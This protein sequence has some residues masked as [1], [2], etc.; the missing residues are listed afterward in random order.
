MYDEPNS[1]L[2]AHSGWRAGV[3]DGC[4]CVRGALL[5]V[6]LLAAGGCGRGRIDAMVKRLF[7]PRLTP[8]QY[9]LIAVSDE[10]PDARR[11]AV[12]RVA[13]S[14]QVG[15]EWALKGLATVAL[16]ETDTQTRCVAIRGLARSRSPQAV[17]VCLKILNWRDQPPREVRPPDD[18]CRW[19]A[20]VALADL[21]QAGVVP[22]EE[23]DAVA[24]TLRRHLRTDSSRHV[25]VAAA[26]GLA[27]YRDVETLRAL[28][29]GL[30]DEDFAVVQ[31]C[32]MSLVALTGQ[33]CDCN[34]Y[35]W[36][37]WLEEHG[38]APFANAGRIPPSRRPPY[39]N[40]LE[41][42]WYDTRQFFRWL[43]PG[44]KQ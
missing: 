38:D 4:R 26:R 6:L 9:M 17:E 11:E 23:R 13:A 7:E 32:E 12:A 40:R 2:R 30:H 8:Q 3:A 20:T 14:G 31:R 33:T 41:K 15:S 24:Q 42:I 37:R 18:L 29:D 28:I 35:A 22:E 44:P 21:S 25:R 10:D 43:F 5:T 19:D 34:P 39:D 36:R 27:C 16:L 1:S